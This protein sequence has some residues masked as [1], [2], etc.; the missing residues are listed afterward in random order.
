MNKKISENGRVVI[1]KNILNRLSLSTGD[2]V[3]FQVVDNK[4]IITPDKTV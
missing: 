4:I 2:I 1:P 3:D